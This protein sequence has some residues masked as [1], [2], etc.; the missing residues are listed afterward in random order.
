MRASD[1]AALYAVEDDLWWFEG[2]RAVT[3]ALLDPVCAPGSDRLILDAGCGTGA[4][5][6]WLPPYSGAGRE[7]GTAAR[8]APPPY[9][10]Q[11]G[12]P[13]LPQRPAPPLPFAPRTA[14]PV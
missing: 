5:L 2:M 1:Y 11:R 7:T 9:C 8:A 13:A 14:H 4:N 3:A 12:R 6:S 10:R